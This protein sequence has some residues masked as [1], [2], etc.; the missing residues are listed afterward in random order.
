L[1][2]PQRGEERPNFRQ[3]RSVAFT[4]EYRYAK[5]APRAH[6]DAAKTDGEATNYLAKGRNR[7]SAVPRGLMATI[8][9]PENSTALNKA[10]PV[11]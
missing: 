8:G 5:S 4:A 7:A 6:C 10:C 1:A 11:A 3:R 2:S 9:P